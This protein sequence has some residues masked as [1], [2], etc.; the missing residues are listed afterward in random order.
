MAKKMTAKQHKIF[1]KPGTK[2]AGVTRQAA[3]KKG[4]KKT[5]KEDSSHWAKHKG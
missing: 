2:M 3:S 4:G 5:A 1:G